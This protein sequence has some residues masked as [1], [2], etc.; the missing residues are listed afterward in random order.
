MQGHGQGQAVCSQLGVPACG[1][2]GLSVQERGAHTD[3]Q[4]QR[5]QSEVGG[6]GT[7]AGALGVQVDGW[8]DGLRVPLRS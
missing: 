7:V 1:C 4:Q 2:V 5:Q 3:R 8:G 6:R